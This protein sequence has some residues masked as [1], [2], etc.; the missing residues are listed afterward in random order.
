M[1]YTIEN[2]HTNRRFPG[3][4]Y[5]EVRLGQTVM[6]SATLAY[7][8]EWVAN[9]ALETTYRYSRTMSGVAHILVYQDGEFLADTG[10]R[11]RLA[12]LTTITENDYNEA[13]GSH[14]PVS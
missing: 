3:M 10:A 4:V 11:Y 2:V 5:A 12:D 14:C 7:C 13:I 9:R 6:V 8:A 1:N